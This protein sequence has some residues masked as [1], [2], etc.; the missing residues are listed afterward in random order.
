VSFQIKVGDDRLVILDHNPG[1]G[2]IV[3]DG[4]GLGGTDDDR[5][6]LISDV[7]VNEASPYAVFKISGAEGSWLS[8]YLT[9]GPGTDADDSQARFGEDYGSGENVFPGIEV[10]NGTTWVAYEAGSRIQ[11]PDGATLLLARVAIINE[12]HYEGEHQFYLHAN[13]YSAETGDSQ[14]TFARGTGIILDDGRGAIFND[15]GEENRNAPKDDDRTLKIDSPIVNEGS[16]YVVF[17]ITG[18]EGNLLLALDIDS[19]EGYADISAEIDSLKNIE[20]WNGSGWVVYDG[21]NAVIPAGETTLLVRVQI[22]AEQDDPYEGSETFKLIAT[23]NSQTSV[24]VATIRDDGTGAYWI[25]DSPVKATPQE[26]RQEDVRLDDDL[27]KD[28]IAPT[29]ETALADLAASQGIGSGLKGDFNGDGI[30]DAE[31]NGLATLAWTSVD[32]FNQAND[33]TLTNVKPI[34]TISIVDSATGE[35]VSS[36]NQLLDIEVV[37]YDD[38]EAFP[39]ALGAVTNANGINTVTMADGSTATTPWDPIRFAVESQTIDGLLTD[40]D[41]NADN[42]T[43]IRIVIDISAAGFDEGSFTA[44]LKYASSEAVAAGIYDLDGNQITQAGWYDFTQRTDGGDGAK[45]ISEG[46]K[47]VA[48][49]LIITDN[50][51]GDNDMETG[52]IFD[53]GMPVSRIVV[54]NRDEVKPLPPPALPA[55]DSRRYDMESIQVGVTG[56][57]A[58]FIYD[59]GLRVAVASDRDASQRWFR[60]SLDDDAI[61]CDVATPMWD[62]LESSMDGK[63]TSGADKA[64]RVVVTECDAHTLAVFR[65]VQDHNFELNEELQFALA[66]DA[67]VHTDLM[68]V[69]KLQATLVNGKALPSWLVFDRTT[70]KFSGKA[71]AMSPDVLAVRV[72][73]RD[74]NGREAAVVFRI[75]LRDKQMIANTGRD[76]FGDQMRM[77][78]RDMLGKRVAT[79]AAA[80]ARFGVR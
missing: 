17:T 72:I 43:Q 68:A 48:I 50:A 30:Q 61:N 11:V 18:E 37:D 40:L 76:G 33:G 4:T 41:G 56:P 9:D 44:Y 24:G 45:F 10:Y 38:P 80:D 34:I 57:D 67:F 69:V 77:A 49:E 8:L 6:L 23:Q 13:S 74:Q 12:T 53:P 51:F 65:G 60:T 63:L 73:A 62:A 14:I 66:P 70:G 55:L 75:N 22:I 16:D 26:L 46:G 47:I 52:R 2:G 29:T 54:P 27:D 58:Q 42:G 25:G 1:I 31:Q 5:T 79:Q 71:P 19:G 59:S 32:A 36:A 28:G 39:D 20:V 35:T 21:T 15:S 3:D 78:S 7:L 64:F